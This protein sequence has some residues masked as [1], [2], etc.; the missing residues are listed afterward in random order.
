MPLPLSPSM[1]RLEASFH[2]TRCALCHGSLRYLP[3]LSRPSLKSTVPGMFV[4]GVGL[5]RMG[6]CPSPVLASDSGLLVLHRGQLPSSTSLLGTC[7]R[8]THRFRTLARCGS[9]GLTRGGAMPTLGC[10]SA[11]GL[12]MLALGGSTCRTF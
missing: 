6:P 5:V 12:V 1:A 7:R 11:A 3:S 9:C 2:A 4:V 8:C 10:F